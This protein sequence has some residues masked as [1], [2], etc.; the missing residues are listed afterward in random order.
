MSI[1][2]DPVAQVIIK[3]PD[4]SDEWKWTSPDYPYLT[5][6]T[7]NYEFNRVSIFSFSVDIPYDV[8]VKLM[9][10][11]SP[12][13]EG[14]LVRARIGYAGEN[15]WTPWVNGFMKEG[16]AGISID[17]NGV[18]G[19]VNVQGTS[20]SYTYEIDEGK[21]KEAGWD[22]EK[23]M[24]VCAEGMGLALEMSPGATEDVVSYLTIG[25]GLEES[26]VGGPGSFPSHL[27]SK[28]YFDIVKSVCSEMNWTFLIAANADEDKDRILR[29]GTRGEFS[30]GNIKPAPYNTYMIRGV[31]DEEKRT[32]PCFAWSPEGSNVAQWLASNPD[33]AAHGV[34][35]TYI[36]DESGET[37][38]IV[39]N[40][41]DQPIPT[42]GSVAKDKP[43]EVVVDD[44]KDD[45]S[46]TDGSPPAHASIPVQPNG[47]ERAKKTSESRQAQG[48]A[49][50]RGVITALGLHDESPGNLCVLRGA[51]LI[52][53]GPYSIRKLTHSYAP[54]SW[55]MS[56]TCQR[57]GR[58]AK[59]GDQ[60]ESPEGQVEVPA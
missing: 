58:L 21:L 8:G 45:E 36:E 10:L 38:T 60:T 28:S 32:Y 9:Q 5:G 19:S 51:G 30:A 15:K 46:R 55:E 17:A 3:D 31:I 52:Y 11:P 4:G 7:I 18:T 40:P 56:L 59:T 54:G 1:F 34:E 14:N 29:I 43:T 6:V 50:Q 25:D 23:I 20:E 37:K 12:F 33:P 49:A 47:E 22:Y 35:I 44:N 13:K 39:V 16:G 48:S 42:V 2:T 27:L 53:D 57:E 26:I 24:G 41:E